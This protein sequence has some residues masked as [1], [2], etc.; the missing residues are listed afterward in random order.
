M[1]KKLIAGNWKSNLLLSEAISLANSIAAQPIS[2]HYELAVFPPEAFITSVASIC[3]TQVFTGAQNCSMY[4]EGAFTGETTARQLQSAG[5]QMVLTGHSE[6]RQLFGET[7]SVIQQKVNKILEAGLTPVFCCGEMLP[8][9]QANQQNQVVLQQLQESLFHLT[10]SDFGKV[11][12]AY[13][14]VWAIGTG[15][16][17]SPAEAEAMHAFIRNEVAQ[18]YSTTTAQTLRILYGGSVKPDNAQELFSCNN[19]D[20]ALVGG[21]SLKVADFLGIAHSINQ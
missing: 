14:P 16:V 1:R 20:G 12:I 21:A 19:V 8:A 9:R 18:K 2:T 4:A 15:V 7:N 6:R 5:V 3:N 10:E 17:A 13:E 11:I